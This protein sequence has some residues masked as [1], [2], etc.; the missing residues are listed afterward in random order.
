MSSGA[1][2]ATERAAAVVAAINSRDP[3][4]LAAVLDE[5]SEVVTGR[6]VHAGPEAITRWAS[7]EYDHLVR[8]YAVDEFRVGR[9]GAILALG[10][11]QYAWTESGDVADS[12]PIGIRIELEG[13]R[14][15]RF[16]LHDDP[17]AALAALDG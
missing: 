15:R 2:E 14:L 5:R 4:T 13:D 7:K 9:T 1:G 16:E 12:S 17:A 6:N 10:H 11:V 3:D 8:S